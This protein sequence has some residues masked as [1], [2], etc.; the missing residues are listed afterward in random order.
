MGPNIGE[1]KPLWEHPFFLIK[2]GLQGCRQNVSAFP[3]FL[4]KADI[5][6]GHGRAFPEYWMYPGKAL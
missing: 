3:T 6:L 4:G 2:R 5:F 1:K